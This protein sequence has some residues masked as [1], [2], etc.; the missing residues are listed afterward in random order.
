M[1]LQL[2]FFLQHQLQF[3]HVAVYLFDVL[4]EENFEQ[5]FHLQYRFHRCQLTMD[6]PTEEKEE[7]EVKVVEQMAHHHYHH[8][9]HY[10]YYYYYYYYY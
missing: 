9:R 7:T 3:F 1:E 10:Y 6:N 8:R 5:D 4:Q 2:Q